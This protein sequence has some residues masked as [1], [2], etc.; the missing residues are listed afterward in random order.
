MESAILNEQQRL[1]LQIIF[2]HFNERGTWPTY[3]YVERT[4][5]QSHP[6][7]DV[8]ELVKSF[9]PGL[10]KPFDAYMFD[11][12]GY[13]NE[14]TFLTVPAIYLCQG[15]EEDLKDFVHVIRF[16]V[17]RYNASE[18]EKRQITSNDLMTL[19][20]MP[21]LSTHKVGLL[22]Q[23]EPWIFSS[24]STGSD[25]NWQCTLSR[26]I[27]RYHD[28]KTIEEYLEKRDLLKGGARSPMNEPKQPSIVVSEG[29]NLEIHPEIYAKCWHLYTARKYDDAILNATKALEV[30]IRTKAQLSADVVGA[31]L[32]NRAFKPDKPILR[33]SNIEAEQ[34]GIMSLLRGMIQVFKN[35][36]SHR[37]VGVQSKSECLS[38]LLMCSNLLFVIENVEYVG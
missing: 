33:Y 19:L 34:E 17:E 6:D 3:S 7:L 9:P 27:R 35:P 21:E 36:Q 28:V 1:Y 23:V 29:W 31:A 37:F 11:V 18:K 30:A 15:S 25:G 24:F 32:V 13:A 4:L 20:D 10:T 14:D 22:L 16:C 5:H 2:D 8:D 12:P 26:P 38:V